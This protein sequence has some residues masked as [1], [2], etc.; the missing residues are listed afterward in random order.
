MNPKINKSKLITYTGTSLI[1]NGRGYEKVD[2]FGINIGNSVDILFAA[3]G[4][5]ILFFITA[6]AMFDLNKYYWAATDKELY[7]FAAHQPE[8]QRPLQRRELGEKKDH[9]DQRVQDPGS[10][11]HHRAQGNASK[12][13]VDLNLTLENKIVIPEDKK[14]LKNPSGSSTRISTAAP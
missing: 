9:P 6:R 5:L 2:S 12:Y 1:L 3:N 4:L 14:E 8:Y 7:N 11:H 10:D 13:E